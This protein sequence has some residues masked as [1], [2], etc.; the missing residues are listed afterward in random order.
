MS[1][2]F[3]ERLKELERMGGDAAAEKGSTLGVRMSAELLQA[4]ASDV[5]ITRS[6]MARELLTVAI[7]EAARELLEA[8]IDTQLELIDP[9]SS[10]A[11]PAFRRLAARRIS[12]SQRSVER[13]TGTPAKPIRKAVK[14]R[15]RAKG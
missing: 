8:G 5:G 9:P 10:E 6:A 12:R 3:V 13:E 4:L 15:P 1:R 11:I 14:G 7:E 2:P